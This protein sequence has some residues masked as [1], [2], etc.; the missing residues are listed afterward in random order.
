MMRV[1]VVVPF[2]REPLEQLEKCIGS[3]HEQAYPTELVTVSDGPLGGLIRSDVDI[4]MRKPHGDFGN[5]ARAA[6]ALHAISMGVDAVAFLDADNWFELDHVA[7]M[8]ALHSE[9]GAPVCT[10]SLLGRR[11]D[12][13]LLYR[14]GENDGERHVDTSCFFLTRAAFSLL[15]LW[16]LI[17]RELAGVGD[18]VFWA[19]VKASGLQRAHC[20]VSTVNYRTAYAVD[21]TS[22]GEEPPP[23]CKPVTQ[24]PIGDWSFDLP[25]VRLRGWARSKE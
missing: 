15:P 25:A 22:R 8:V 11:L 18:R 3:V 16:A 6:G 21:Y 17:P 7:R 12:G 5:C 2:C 23:G 9:S 20:H 14:N 1:A 19:M 4:I 13:S 24:L 10:A